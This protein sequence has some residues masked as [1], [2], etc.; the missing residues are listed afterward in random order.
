MRSL[1]LSSA[2]D[3]T[4]GEI[5]RHP[6]QTLLAR[7]NTFP[8][9]RNAIPSGGPSKHR[10]AKGRSALSGSRSKRAAD[11]SSTLTA[12]SADRC[13]TPITELY[14]AISK[15]CGDG[16]SPESTSNTVL[17]QEHTT[18]HDDFASRSIPGA[19]PH[20]GR[21]VAP[22]NTPR[23]A[24]GGGKRAVSTP[25]GGSQRPKQVKRAPQTRRG[26]EL[27]FL[28]RV[29]ATTDTLSQRNQPDPRSP[30]ARRPQAALPTHPCC[31]P[32][33]RNLKAVQWRLQRGSRRTGVVVR[34]KGFAAES[35]VGAV[36]VMAGLSDDHAADI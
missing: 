16:G 14:Q 1:S 2:F 24:T 23:L 34:V 3:L 22:L 12:T 31:S 28:C 6:P 19:A 35:L 7:N 4:Q 25:R 17:M 20:R 18:S 32:A 27:V 5:S 8:R 15:I 33:R 21:G 26:D 10:G 13:S 11:V 36:W 29:P 9:A 30:L